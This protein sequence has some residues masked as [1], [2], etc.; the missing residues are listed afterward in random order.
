MIA[1]V[2]RYGRSVKACTVLAGTVSRSSDASKV[3]VPSDWIA[4]N[5]SGS[6]D[7]AVAT[8]SPRPE[9][10]AAVLA[11]GS[12]PVLHAATSRASS[13]TPATRA[14]VNGCM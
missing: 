3:V 1:C 4:N 10:S 9:P 14:A 2:S 8:S 11:S 5:H 12:F 13:A 7:S 6:V